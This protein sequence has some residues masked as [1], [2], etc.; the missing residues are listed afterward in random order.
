M[1]HVISVSSLNFFHIV[2]VF[3]VLQRNSLLQDLYL[4]LQ[5]S[6]SFSQRL[7]LGW[8]LFVCLITYRRL[9]CLWSFF[10]RSFHWRFRIVL[11]LLLEL[12]FNTLLFLIIR[13][14]FVH[15]TLPNCLR[16]NTCCFTLLGNRLISPSSWF[17]SFCRLFGLSEFVS[18]ICDLLSQIL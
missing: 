15:G 1:L 14:S 9:W 16:S 8:T 17:S 3:F 18:Q 12:V 11:F 2:I 4:T 7:D 13:V 10:R 5:F 6:N